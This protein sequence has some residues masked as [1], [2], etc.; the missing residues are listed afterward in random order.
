MATKASLH[1]RID[2][3]Q[4]LELNK[5]HF[6]DKTFCVGEETNKDNHNTTL[7]INSWPVEREV[8]TKDHRSISEKT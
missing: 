7:Y 6:N 5:R 4:E 2:N 1:Q 3:I 8:E